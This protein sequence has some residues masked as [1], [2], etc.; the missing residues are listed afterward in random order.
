MHIRSL[1][2]GITTKAKDSSG[3]FLYVNG[4]GQLCYRDSSNN[5]IIVTRDDDN[6]TLTADTISEATAGTGVTVDSVLLIDGTVDLNGVADSVILDTDGDTTISSPTDD[7]IDFEVGGTD[8]LR[9]VAA[10]LVEGQAL[11]TA[12]TGVTAVHHSDGRNITSVFTLSAIS[13]T[14]AGA[15]AEA[16][17]ALIY[18]FPAGAHFHEVT[19]MNITLTGGGTVDAD[20]P[21]VGIGSVIGT[22]AVS[23]LSGTPTFEDYIT[24]QT[25]TDCS[26]TAIVAMT[27]ATAGIHTGISLNASGDVKA[28]NVNVAD[29][30][31]G[32]DTITL[33][34]TVT[35]KWTAMS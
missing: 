4:D 22:G 28:V 3:L 14:I 7:Q 25:A 32:A 15:A 12:G 29:T 30:W 21:D 1:K 2:S 10:G 31:A 8:V 11:G 19:Y 18:T 9:M 6:T 24:G 20:T 26:G 16:V 35:M 5:E 17:G 34:G 23:V 13:L 27:G 33:A